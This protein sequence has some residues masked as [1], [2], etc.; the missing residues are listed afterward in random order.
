MENLKPEYR[1]KILAILR[2]N[3]KVE[4]AMLFGSRAMG[5]GRVESDV[6]LCLFGDALT[7]SDQARLSHELE[8]TT[9]PQMIDLV[10]YRNIRSE[11][12]REHLNRHGKVVFA[13]NNEAV[14]TEW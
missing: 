3:P 8:E 9:I 7:L 2:R 10:L 14:R 13:R 6:D 12:L 11:P 4:K 5:T 1:E